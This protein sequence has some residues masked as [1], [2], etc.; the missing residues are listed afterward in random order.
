MHKMS[1]TIITIV[2]DTDMCSYMLA[3]CMCN[4]AYYGTV[5]MYNA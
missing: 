3:L 2:A 5:A 4:L 1:E